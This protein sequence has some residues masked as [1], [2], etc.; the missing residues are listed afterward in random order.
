MIGIFLI[1]VI[2]LLEWL[3]ETIGCC[4]G[5]NSAEL[6]MILGVGAVLMTYMY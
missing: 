4:Q 3:G 1:A 6:G 5:G 2:W